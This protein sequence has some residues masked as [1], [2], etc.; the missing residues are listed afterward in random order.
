MKDNDVTVVMVELVV[1]LVCGGSG[2]DRKW[3]AACGG[4]GGVV[5]GE[6]ERS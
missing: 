4:C 1:V 6:F 2:N 5:G 3:V